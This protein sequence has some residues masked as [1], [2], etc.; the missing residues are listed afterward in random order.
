MGGFR[1]GSTWGDEEMRGCGDADRPR[2]AFAARGR[3]ASPHLPIPHRRN[4]N[5]EGIRLRRLPLLP[6]R[7]PLEWLEGAGLIEMEHEVEL[8]GEIGE[9]VVA[10]PLR[11]RTIDHADG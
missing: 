8:R 7:A 9:E 3:I 2:E 4:S 10:V 6:A 1:W 11:L 5:G